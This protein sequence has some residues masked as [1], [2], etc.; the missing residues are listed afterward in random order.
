[1]FNPDLPDCIVNPDVHPTD[2]DWRA[3]A[4]EFEP[5]RTTRL[6][7]ARC[8][9]K[10]TTPRTPRE[11]VE[12]LATHPGDSMAWINPPRLQLGPESDFDPVFSLS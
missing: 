1:M 3:I 8:G 9:R 11:L 2:H 7:C 5:A 12:F 4:V 10:G 6:V